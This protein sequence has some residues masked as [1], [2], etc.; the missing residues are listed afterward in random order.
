MIIHTPYFLVI[1]FTLTCSIDYIIRTAYSYLFLKAQVDTEELCRKIFMSKLEP[2]CSCR[3]VVFA[4]I[5]RFSSPNRIFVL[6]Q[7][8]APDAGGLSALG[9]DLFTCTPHPYHFP[10][11]RL[12]GFLVALGKSC[13]ILFLQAALRSQICSYF[14]S[15]MSLPQLDRSNLCEKLSTAVLVSWPNSS[16]Q[17]NAIFVFSEFS[18]S[19]AT[20]CTVNTR[21]LRIPLS[22]KHLRAP[23][24]N[25]VA[26][27]PVIGNPDAIW[28]HVNKLCVSKPSYYRK[29]KICEVGLP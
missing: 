16:V 21:N 29:C 3:L 5:I 6:L 26:F 12:H 14:I 22:C 20:D 8:F 9:D 24:V 11:S 15:A 4:C 13:S 10:S 2:N 17:R 23:H 27:L 25:S 19:L 7:I 1:N 18:W 28:P